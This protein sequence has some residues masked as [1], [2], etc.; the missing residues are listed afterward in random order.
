MK[1]LGNDRL[2]AP[3]FAVLEHHLDAMWMR[4]AARENASD[5]AFGQAA[6]ALVLFLHDLHTQSR[7]DF[8]PFGYGH[9]DIGRGD[10]LSRSLL[11][12]LTTRHITVVPS[13]KSNADRI[14]AVPQKKPTTNKTSATIQSVRLGA[15]RCS[16]ISTSFRVGCLKILCLDIEQTR[17]CNSD[18][19]NSGKRCD[20]MQ[21]ASLPRGNM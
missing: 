12:I 14:N 4:R 2:H 17:I 11:L 20:L 7:F 10:I 8:I 9:L 5:N 18:P 6:S 3:D 19:F 16:L 1:A 15:C 13:S 21:L